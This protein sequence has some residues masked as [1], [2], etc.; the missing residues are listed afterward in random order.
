MP[1]HR[2]AQGNETRTSAGSTTLI[3]ISDHGTRLRLKTLVV[4]ISV[5]AGSGKVEIT[6][7]TT[8]YFAWEAITTGGGQPPSVNIPDGFDWG[9]N[10]DII[11]TTTGAITVHA[12]CTAEVR[13]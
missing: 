5:F 9:A 10:K 2:E 11:L 13:G 12:V 4:G 7:G 3:D 6:D 8:T 1:A